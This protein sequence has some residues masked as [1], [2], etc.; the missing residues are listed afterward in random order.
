MAKLKITDKDKG[1]K[2]I[3]KDFTVLKNA[4][5]VKVGLVGPDAGAVHN[6]GDKN[7]SLPVA[8]IGMIHEYGSESRG[9][10]ERSFIRGPLD[11]HLGQI[12]EAMTSLSRKVMLQTME[13]SQALGLLGLLGVKIMKNAITVDR[14]PPPLKPATIKAKTRDGKTGDTPLVDTAQMLNTLKHQVVISGKEDE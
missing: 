10:P 11:S 1:W 12:R 3:V 5:Y 13:A 7:E 9:I 4:P 14:V 6:G 2:K 8:T